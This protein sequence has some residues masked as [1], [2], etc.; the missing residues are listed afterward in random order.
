LN[1]NSLQLVAYSDASFANRSDKSSQIGYV[2]CLTDSSK[3]CC[4]L[5]FRSQKARRV[6]RSSTAGET[7]AFAEAF[8]AAFI[9]KHDLT[10][11]LNKQ[12]PLLMLNDSESLFKTLTRS[13]YTTERRLLVDIA[14][15]GQAYHSREI[16]NIGLIASQD[17]V[18][19]GMT[20]LGPNSALH[21]FLTYTKIDHAV[22]QWVIE[23]DMRS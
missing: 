17:N 19:D 7:L 9:L 20:K 1:V 11:M 2:I 6:V 23:K 18:A 5:Q 8:D 10:T 15:A 4:I 22:Q 13:R 16:S 3:Q 14:A 21:R 12:I